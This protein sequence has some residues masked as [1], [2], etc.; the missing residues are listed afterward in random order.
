MNPLPVQRRIERFMDKPRDDL[1]YRKINRLTAIQLA[2]TSMV[3]LI[4]AIVAILQSGHAQQLLLRVEVLEARIEQLESAPP[5][6]LEPADDLP[7]ATPS[8]SGEKFAEKLAEN[9]A[10]QRPPT[11]PDAARID[12]ELI[13]MVARLRAGM[14]D[15][16]R[17][18][19]SALLMRIG[20]DESSSE[21]SAGA[22]LAAAEIA[23]G[24]GDAP[25][26]I[27]WALRARSGGEGDPRV[28]RLLATAHE[29]T[30]D[31]DMAIEEARIAVDSG[32]A[33]A[34]SLRLLGRLEGRLATVRLAAGDI[35]GCVEAARAA[36]GAGADDPQVGVV[37]GQ[38]LLAG[39]DLEGAT[40]TL[41]A[42]IARK[43]DDPGAWFHLGRAR[44]AALDSA[45]AANAFEEAVRIDPAS[46]DSWYRLGVARANA[47]QCAA[48]VGAFDNCV[49]LDP[50]FA[51]AH[52][53]R[54]ICQ[55]RM[56]DTAA[57]EQSLIRSLA[58]DGSLMQQAERVPVLAALL[59][60]MP[61]GN[62]GDLNAEEGEADSD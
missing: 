42:V 15:V 39:G 48:A 35:D 50:A 30:G 10:S 53:A 43:P 23:M 12:E 24:L 22:C 18:E 56:G 37:L 26:C 49:A 54:A 31:L 6:V 9:Q 32:G 4:I 33:P 36:I 17:R 11:P 14:S 40:D 1:A 58:L 27:G 2:T 28:A 25:G 20:I 21:I 7:S 38:C 57:A 13:A 61:E 59:A 5:P 62:V 29:Q 52:F 16:D 60:A 8:V 47:D 34:E 41:R 45:G 51:N 3:I 19:A 46:A 44:L 55:A